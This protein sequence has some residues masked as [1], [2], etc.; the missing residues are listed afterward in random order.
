MEAQGESQ[1]LAHGPDKRINHRKKFLVV[2][3]LLKALVCALKRISNRE[4]PLTHLPT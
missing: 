1:N 4:K 3:R 2:A